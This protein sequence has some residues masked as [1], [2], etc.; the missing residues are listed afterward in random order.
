MGMASEAEQA[1]FER[2]CMYYP[3]LEKAR[4]EFELTLE[5]KAMANAIPP[6]AYL[7]NRIMEQIRQEM[8]VKTEARVISSEKFR[9][10]P[11]RSGGMRWAIAA[12]I[13]LIMGCG[14]F[15][16]LMH[17]KA[18]HYKKEIASSKETLDG[19]EQRSRELEERLERESAP[20]E[21]ARQVSPQ[22][23]LKATIS[24][25]WDSTNANVY[26]I[27]KNLSPLPPGQQ[28]QVWSLTKGK[29]K[30]LGV[31]DAPVR[32]DKLILKVDNAQEADAFAI[33]IEKSGN[34]AGPTF[35][36]PGKN[37]Q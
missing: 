29:Y 34:Q 19:M 24:V 22:K 13:L 28:Y 17:K 37:P 33:T 8:P 18:Q 27:I 10:S 5:K 12:S 11:N 30:S 31:F 36:Q 25:F 7:K 14:L 4:I 3:E 9:A 16:Y 26:L 32:D 2:L 20:V 1:E 23:N 21:Q 6:P 15:V 35:D